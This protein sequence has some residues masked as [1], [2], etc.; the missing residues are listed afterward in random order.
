MAVLPNLLSVIRLLLVPVLLALARNGYSRP[1]LYCLVV[2]LLTD[3]ADGFL[4]RRFNATSKLGAKLD[5]WADFTTY[6]ALPFCGWWLRP[7]VLRAE[8]PFLVTP[9]FFYLAA[10]G[11]GFLKYRRLTS[12]HTW[13][14]KTVAILAG[15]V[16][17]TFFLGGPGWP[18]RVLAP[19][20][21]LSLLEEIAITALLAQWHANVPSLWHARQIKSR[22]GDRK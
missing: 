12:Y 7:D 15:A 14:S 18:F 22:G 13:I 11:F 6:L 10:V 20:A 19:L 2:S 17:L 16:V 21:V 9:I 5:S 1:F 8:A 4:A 3:G